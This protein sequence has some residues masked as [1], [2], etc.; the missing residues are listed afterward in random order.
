M[1][2]LS[3]QVGPRLPPTE[4]RDG[5]AP[6]ILQPSV[7]I[8]PGWTDERGIRWFSIESG[9][10]LLTGSDW[11]RHTECSH[12]SKFFFFFFFNRSNLQNVFIG[13]FPPWKCQLIPFLETVQSGALRLLVK[14]EVP[15]KHAEYMY[16][17]TIGEGGWVGV[18]E[19]GPGFTSGPSYS[20]VTALTSEP[21]CSHNT[22]NDWAWHADSSGAESDS[23]G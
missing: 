5:L 22:L 11:T 14:R 1:N 12:Q 23:W 13:L 21:L 2:R 10:Q 6:A 4:S 9:K 18:G 20:D 17:H 15:C 7:Q 3:V 19:W 8:K 16:G